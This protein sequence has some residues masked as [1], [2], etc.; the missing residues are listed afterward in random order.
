MYQDT[1][2]ANQLTYDWP[3][4]QPGNAQEIEAKTSYSGGHVWIVLGMSNL[5]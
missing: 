4:V 1:G 5:T 3:L 2:L